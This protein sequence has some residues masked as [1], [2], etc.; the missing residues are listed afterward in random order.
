[1]FF[2]YGNALFQGRVIHTMGRGMFRIRAKSVVPKMSTE[3]VV[4]EDDVFGNAAKAA[5]ACK[6]AAEY[7]QTREREMKEVEA[8]ALEE[9]LNADH[10]RQRLEQ[11]EKD[12]IADKVHREAIEIE[13]I[14]CLEKVLA[15][16]IPHHPDLPSEIALAIRSGKIKN[17]TINY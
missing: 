10:E 13:A 3:F 4:H 2:Q 7:W 14:N 5:K 8:K 12:R 6:A 1:V 16:Y 17:I 11:I 9:K 15:E